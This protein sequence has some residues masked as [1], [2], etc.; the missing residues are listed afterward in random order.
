MGGAVEGDRYV[1]EG[2]RDRRLGLVH[3]H[4][5]GADPVVREAGID[6]TCGE[7]LDEVQ[8]LSRHNGHQL[9]GEIPVVDRVGHI[10]GGRG[11]TQVE[12]EGHVDDKLL[13]FGSFE[14][15]DAMVTASA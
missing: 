5:G 3:S 6:Q 11:P 1:G 9:S 10:V 14:V 15:I 4:R 7:G 8:R 2:V 12:L 13:T